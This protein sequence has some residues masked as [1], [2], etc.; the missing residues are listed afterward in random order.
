MSRSPVAGVTVPPCKDLTGTGGS[1]AELIF[2]AGYCRHWCVL[3]RRYKHIRVSAVVSFLLPLS[4]TSDRDFKELC[5][6]IVIA[7]LG[8]QDAAPVLI[9]FRL[10]SLQ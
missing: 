5:N 2:P 4:R 8:L 6:F 3:A 1:G 7:Q 9:S 10:P